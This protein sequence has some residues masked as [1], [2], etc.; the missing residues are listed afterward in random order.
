[1]TTRGELFGRTCVLDVGDTRI[2]DLRIAFRVTKKLT[3]DPN[4]L[5]VQVYNLSDSTRRKIQTKGVPVRLL[6]GYGEN[7]ET[8]FSGDVSLVNHVHQGADWVTRLQSG[9][10]LEKIRSARTKSSFGKGVKITDVVKKLAEDT[11]LS[12]GNLLQGLFE[13]LSG[14]PS[15]YAKGASHS[16]QAY[17]L[18]ERTVG[19]LGLGL[20]VQDGALQVHKLDGTGVGTEIVLLSVGT[21]LVG[22][23]EVCEEEVKGTKRRVIKARSL[24]QQRLLPGR[25]VQLDSIALKGIFR[26]EQVQ[27]VGDTHG[28]PWYAELEL[29]QSR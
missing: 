25:R 16:G 24:I 27:F 1:M 17:D 23:P 5:D 20:S 12:T 11:G 7:L 13:V 18:L 14:R 26:V 2:R 4:T 10:G 19:S 8:V 15:E 28:E 6:A 21:G 9:D 29:V 3:K 22:S